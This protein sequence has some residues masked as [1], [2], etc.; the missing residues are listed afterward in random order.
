[1]QY[2]PRHANHHRSMANWQRKSDYLLREIVKFRTYM[3]SLAAAHSAKER[4]YAK[5]TEHGYGAETASI[6]PAA[7]P[8]DS[9]RAM[10][11]G[12]GCPA[13]AT[14]AGDTAGCGIESWAR[15]GAWVLLCVQYVLANYGMDV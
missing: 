5:R 8:V 11:G 3:D 4:F 6:K 1:M 7:S 13:Y 9:G 15:G 2:S 12:Q 10:K 14:G